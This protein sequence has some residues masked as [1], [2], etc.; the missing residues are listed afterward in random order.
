MREGKVKV[1]NDLGLHARAAAK[2][3]KTAGR[4]KSKIVLQNPTYDISADGRSILNVLTLSGSNG[5]LL[6]INVTG[7]D[8]D[9]AYEAIR[10]LFATGFGE[11]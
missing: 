5:S 4:Y 10:D 7:E 9:E 2:L 6:Q 1:I 3:V 8:E 11:I